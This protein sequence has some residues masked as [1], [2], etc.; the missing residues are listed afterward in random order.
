MPPTL[1]EIDSFLD[2]ASPDAYDRVVDRLLATPRYGEHM[3]RQ[4]LDVARYGDTHGFHLDNVRSLW[5]WRDWVIEAF[6]TNM[7]LDRFT[8]E[9]LAGDLLPEPT[10][11]QRVATGFNRCNPTTG[12][13]GLIAEEYLVKYA[14]DRVETTGLA[15]MGLTVGCAQCHDHKYDPISQ[16]EFYRLFAFF[17]NVGEDASDKNA[18]VPPPSMRVM[19]PEQKRALAEI[20]RQLELARADLDAPMSELDD[21]QATWERDQAA[22]TRTLWQELE[23]VSALSRGGASMR[24]LED[25]SILVS[26]T[27]P[28]HDVYEVVAR[29]EARGITAVRLEALTDETQPGGGVGRA[30]HSNIVLTDFAVEAAPAS[31]PLAGEPIAIADAY[32]DYSQRNYDIRA[33]IDSDKESGWA[34]DRGRED[35]AAVFAAKE[36]FGFDGGTILRIRL[37]HESRHPQHTIGRFRLSLSTAPEASPSDVR[38]VATRSGRSRRPTPRPPSG[39]TSGPRAGPGLEETYGDKAP[40]MAAANGAEGRRGASSA[41]AKGSPVPAADHRRAQRAHHDRRPGQR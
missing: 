2:D 13:G 37:S 17:N 14:I 22:V 33:A 20:E 29:T 15:W 39:P 25:R 16:V 34:I 38:C 18:L 36:S 26:G 8:V 31:R 6:N 10:D 41:R 40:S 9:Q 5:P 27:S 7:P 30:S 35:R 28:Q 12:E 21:V 23:P 1:E 11:N 3:A 4:W 19:A 32:A 24:I